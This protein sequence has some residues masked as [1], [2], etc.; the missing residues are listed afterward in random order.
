MGYV[1]NGHTLFQANIDVCPGECVT[2][3]VE[4][5]IIRRTG[6][7]GSFAVTPER[8]DA[9]EPGLLDRSATWWTNQSRI[10][11]QSSHNVLNQCI[12]IQINKTIH[13]DTYLVHLPDGWC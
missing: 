8:T 3:S 13:T 12:V 11:E 10:N 7:I 6:R 9:K 1:G 4:P 2:A 5:V